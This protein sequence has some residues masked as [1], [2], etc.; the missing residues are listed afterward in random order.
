MSSNPVEEAMNRVSSVNLHAYSA[1]LVGVKG[2]E[3]R[4][5]PITPLPIPE[6]T[7]P[8]TKT[9]FIFAVLNLYVDESNGCR[10]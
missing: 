7:P 10:S 3:E 4:N 5:I 1:F 9:Y 8:D 6:M 2:L